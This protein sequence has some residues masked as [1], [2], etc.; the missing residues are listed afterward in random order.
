MFLRLVD[1]FPFSRVSLQWFVKRGGDVLLL[2][3]G[4]F[5]LSVAVGL[6]KSS[7]VLI[8]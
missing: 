3:L 7:V 4:F 1:R 5:E 2:F 6:A 8:K